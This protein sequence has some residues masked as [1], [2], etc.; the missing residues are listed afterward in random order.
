MTSSTDFGPRH[1]HLVGAYGE[2]WERD[3]VE[4]VPGRG[5]QWQLLGRLDRVNTGAI[6]VCD[7]RAARGIYILHDD[8][9]AAYVGMARGTRGLGQRLRAHHLNPPRGLRWSRFSWYSFDDVTK[10]ESKKDDNGWRRLEPRN[11]IGTIGAESAAREME[12]LVIRVLGTY[13]LGQ[14]EMGFDRG[15]TH[16]WRQVTSA[17][18]YPRGLLTRVDRGPL[19]DSR[20]R[21]WLDELD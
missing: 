16:E 20:L 13:R 15:A 19:T 8:H 17:D 14:I 5:R 9:G 6:G 18:T 10:P 7:F 3:E 11:D 12:A 21:D 2:F 4:W 1:G